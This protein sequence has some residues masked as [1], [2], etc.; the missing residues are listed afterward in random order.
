MV[1]RALLASKLLY[2]V[3]LLLAAC[4]NP[5]PMVYVDAATVLPDRATGLLYHNAAPVT[6]IVFACYPNGDTALLQPCRNGREEG[7]VKQW[8]PGGQVEAERWYHNGKKEGLHRGWWPDGKVKFAYHFSNGEYNGGVEEWYNNG[9]PF[10]VMHYRDGH[11]E[12]MQKMW[13]FNGQIKANY[14]VFKNRRY[15]L[16]GTKN[17]INL[18]DSILAKR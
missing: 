4:S 5:T 13:Y 1:R 16:S 14:A 12:G 6:G 2:G 9:Q 7:C 17:C 15:G 10:R 11:E 8:Y 3:C 18:P